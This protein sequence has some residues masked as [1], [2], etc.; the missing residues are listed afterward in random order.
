MKDMKRAV[1]RGH[2]ARLKKKWAKK[3]RNEWYW[4]EDQVDEENVK[5]WSSMYTRTQT[6]CSSC[7]GCIN[8][9]KYEGLTLQEQRN[10]L[11]YEEQID[12]L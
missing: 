1:R 6:V 12:G 10:L 5:R 9:R 11:S 8:P 4:S 3:L 2:Y 7:Y